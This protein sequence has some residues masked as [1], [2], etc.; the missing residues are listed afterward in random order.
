M[1]RIFQLG[2]NGS[3][4]AQLGFYAQSLRVD[5]L[6]AGLI[7]FPDNSWACTPFT[8]GFMMPVRPAA[9]VARAVATRVQGL[10][11]G[12]QDATLEWTDEVWV[13]AAGIALTGSQLISV[14]VSTIPFG[15]SDFLVNLFAPLAGTGP[16]SSTPSG[17]LSTWTDYGAQLGFWERNPQGAYAAQGAAGTYLIALDA[18]KQGNLTAT[19]RISIHG[20]SDP[21]CNAGLL[22]NLSS[23]DATSY[24]LAEL[25]FIGA[26]Q[27]QFVVLQS[28]AGAITVLF[29]A[30]L[31]V[32]ITPIGGTITVSLSATTL[33]YTYAD[34]NTPANN[35]SGTV[36]FAAALKGIDNTLQGLYSTGNASQQSFSRFQTTYP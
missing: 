14:Q 1:K 34:G 24:L 6:T 12:N 10:T 31:P 7:T 17:S 15:F 30:L 27:A 13:P 3:I 19:V 22:L 16:D 2:A 26:S 8:L 11:S 4:E 5:N 23:I 20:A 36:A 32:S 18:G 29:A 25:T 33:T 9:S 21:P 28:V 35:F